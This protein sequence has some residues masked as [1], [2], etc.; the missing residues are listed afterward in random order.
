[1]LCA[2]W[3]DTLCT[4]QISS[5]DA[6]IKSSIVSKCLSSQ[7]Q[8]AQPSQALLQA[9]RSSPWF[10]AVKIEGLALLLHTFK[11]GFPYSSVGKESTCNAG[12]LGSIPGLGRAPGEG[13]CY[14]F[15]YSGLENSMDCIV[16]GVTKNWT[17][18]SDFHFTLACNNSSS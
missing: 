6:F 13:K 12:D 15:Q 18:L 17:R 14:P 7:I 8:E 4:W 10:W 5:K 3:T 1:M 9:S 2:V 11:M 16:C